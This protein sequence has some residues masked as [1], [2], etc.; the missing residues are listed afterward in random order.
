LNCPDCQ[1][2]ARCKGVRCRT[3]LSLLGTL[4]FHRH[5]YHCPQC[6]QGT[7]PRDHHLGLQA[8]DLTPAAEEVVCLAG[9]QGSF[10]DAATKLLPRLTALHVAESTV[11]RATEAAG[12]RVG[13]AHAAG[14]TFGPPTPWPW[15]KDRDGQSVAYV[16]VDATGVGQQG[17]GG[18]RADGRMAYVG[19]I[20]N[21]VPEERERWA[22]PDG[23]RPD[24]QA[25]YVT[26]V[27]PLAA[28]AGP[29]RRQAG[30]VGIDQADR[31]IALS[32]GG[33]G[34][35]DFLAKNF[36][37]V[38]AVILDFYHV[39]EYLGKLAKALYPSQ[40]EEAE[41]WRK[42]WCTRLKAE[43]GGPVLAALRDLPVSG[44]AAQAVRAEVVKY[45]ANQVQRMDYPT[46][47][48]KGWQIGSGPVESACKTVVGQR[49]KGGGMR[50]GA[51]G[52]D[53]VCHLRALF[54][55]ERGQWEAFWKQN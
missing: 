42:A 43:G 7:F 16:S 29:L 24:W 51:D 48:A 23:R 20:Y 5:Y 53:A 47:V 35:E 13:A 50:W 46:Y 12:G 28:L 30:Q 49:L 10:A 27:Q 34:L 14:Q 18:R 9:L 41:N 25:R 22:N 40:D 55:S 6:H 15:H 4:R 36:A 32:D 26:Q 39:T 54:R 17:P 33:A 31:W 2:D 38:S 45:F 44:R 19:M 52:A 11:E 8:H 3:L 37:R 21:P 1:Q